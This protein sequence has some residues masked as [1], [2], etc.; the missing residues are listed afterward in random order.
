MPINISCVSAPCGAGKTH[1]TANYI[2]KNY[3]LQNF[4]YTAPT[5]QLLGEM[6]ER[7][8]ERGVPHTV[9]TS[10]TNPWTATNPV[11][12]E[13]ILT[14]EL[15]KEDAPEVGRVLLITWKAYVELRYFHRPGNWQVIHD[16]IPQLDEFLPYMLPVNKNFLTDFVEIG[17]N[18]NEKI[19]IVKARDAGKNKSQLNQSQDDVEKIFSKLRKKLASDNWEVFVNL[20]AYARAAEAKAARLAKREPGKDEHRPRSGALRGAF[21]FLALLKAQFVDGAIMLGAHFEDSLLYDWFTRYYGVKFVPFEPIM[22]E[23]QAVSPCNREVKIRYL[24]DTPFFSKELANRT[25][26]DSEQILIDRMD[27][28]VLDHYGD[29]KFLYVENK[30]RAS[31]I[32]EKAPNAIKIPV[33]C[34]GTNKYDRYN[35]IY[36]SASLNRPPQQ[37][38]MLVDLGFDPKVIQRASVH[39]VIYQAVMRTSLRRPNARDAVT[40]IVPD[41]AAAERTAELLGVKNVEK[42]EKSQLFLPKKKVPLTDTQRHSKSKANRVKEHLFGRKRTQIAITLSKGNCVQNRSNGAA[43]NEPG[44]DAAEAASMPGKTNRPFI[45]LTFHEGLRDCYPRQ[46]NVRHCSIHDFVTSMRQLSKEVIADKEARTLFNPT[47]FK[48]K[49]EWQYRTLANFDKCYLLVLDIDGGD[50]TPQMIEDIFWN[51]AI[52]KQKRPHIVCNSY[53]RCAADPNRYRV[54]F[55]LKEPCRSV[56][57]YHAIYDA[58]TG[59]IA[60][61]TFPNVAKFD[62]QARSGVHSFFLPC[63]NKEH[64]NYAFFRFYGTRATEIDQYGIVPSLC[65]KNAHQPQDPIPWRFPSTG[66]NGFDTNTLKPLSPKLQEMKDRIMTMR[67]GRHEIFFSFAGSVNKFFDGDQLAVERHLRDIA[68]GSSKM[69]KWVT[70]ALRSIRQY[71]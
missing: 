6:S 68:G 40:V 48:P 14:A 3:L 60:E 15:K 16:E 56:A 39:E 10:K 8:T 7:L 13:G 9:I 46:F 50:V 34:H 43:N 38:G 36:F 27:Q 19:G 59:R 22:K 12:V 47:V 37:L 5:L 45:A 4:V 31:A 30:D 20:E 24:V 17:H 70:D 28:E 52:G 66:T 58:I 35:A 1:G 61:K 29:E 11:S 49:N 51:E 32:L 23:L 2:A 64:P 53:S 18:L 54:M 42:L 55:F 65:L 69:K 44:G 41:R 33:M 71:S 26:T 57:E 21:Y 67:K 63:T 25:L 62:S